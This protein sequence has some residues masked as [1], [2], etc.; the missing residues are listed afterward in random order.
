MLRFAEG[1]AIPSSGEMSLRHTSTCGRSDIE[2]SH[3]VIG[4]RE[5]V[6]P[7]D[8]VCPAVLHREFVLAS[9]SRVVTKKR[10][11]I[12]LFCAPL[13]TPDRRP[14]DLDRFVAATQLHQLIRRIGAGGIV[15]Q[16][17]PF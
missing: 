8:A 2:V 13:A 6:T 7:V 14:G 10:V 1:L 12:R 5:P 11:K 4:A 3:G 17:F 9:G 15:A 16:E